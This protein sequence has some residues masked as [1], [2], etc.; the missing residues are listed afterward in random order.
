MTKL[1]GPLVLVGCG[2]MGGA[3]L[4]GWLAHGLA[5]TDVLVVEPDAGMREPTRSQHGIVA[6]AEACL[7][8]GFRLPQPLNIR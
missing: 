4:R 6:V 1:A 3:L 5:A 2:K 7:Q 8:L